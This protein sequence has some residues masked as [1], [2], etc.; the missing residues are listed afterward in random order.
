MSLEHDNKRL[1]E[2]VGKRLFAVLDSIDSVD[3]CV[4]LTI[5][6]SSACTGMDAADLQ[7][8]ITPLERTCRWTLEIVAGE[9]QG[10]TYS[11]EVSKPQS[12]QVPF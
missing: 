3:D 2:Q 12:K 8:G 10:T 4:R 11:E 7:A 5:E 1:R 6:I 9:L